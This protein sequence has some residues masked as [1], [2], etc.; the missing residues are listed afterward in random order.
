MGVFFSLLFVDLADGQIYTR[1]ISAEEIRERLDGFVREQCDNDNIV[2]YEILNIQMPNNLYVPDGNYKIILTRNSVTEPKGHVLVKLQIV[3]DGKIIKTG[4][5]NFLLRCW[6]KV[7]I[8]NRTI[9]KNKIIEMGWVR[10]DTVET[11]SLRPGYVTD[12]N[13]VL[14]NVAA[15]FLRKGDLVYDR[16][17]ENL[18]VIR[19]G[20]VVDL[21]YVR[22]TIKIV[23]RVKALE[24]GAIGENIRVL[25]LQNKKRMQV[26][27]INSLQVVLP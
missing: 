26:K 2:K 7:V 18:P 6:E 19:K 25:N 20:A 13:T 21:V 1:K 16:D 17:I 14:G 4:T 11:T 3:H 27:V 12:I 22:G 23:L 15:G 5:V 8:A 10:T 24:D 9:E